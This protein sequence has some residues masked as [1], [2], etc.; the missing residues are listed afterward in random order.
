MDVEMEVERLRDKTHEMSNHA[1]KL[2]GRI[3]KIETAL[4]GHEEL[5]E[6]RDR[7]SD[8]RMTRLENQISKLT[9]TS[10]TASVAALGAVVWQIFIMRGH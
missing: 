9:F 10:L 1:T 3:G 2:D 5:C 4:E 7:N 6:V 8:R